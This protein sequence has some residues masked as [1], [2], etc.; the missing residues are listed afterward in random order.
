[1]TAVRTNGFLCR[2]RGAVGDRDAFTSLKVI[3]GRIGRWRVGRPL[4]KPLV[5]VHEGR[6]GR[7]RV[8]RAG[9]RV[10]FGRVALGVKTHDF[11]AGRATGVGQHKGVRGDASPSA[12][13][14]TG[15]LDFQTALRVRKVT[16]MAVITVITVIGGQGGLTAKS[17][18]AAWVF[19]VTVITVTVYLPFRVHWGSPEM[20]D[21]FT[22]CHFGVRVVRL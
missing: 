3:N 19:R 1:M 2:K 6:V 16:V 20:S 17:A 18:C 10:A 8:G 13:A 5:G 11:A 9:R 12:T 21:N 15:D 7:W 14:G 4:V 22:D